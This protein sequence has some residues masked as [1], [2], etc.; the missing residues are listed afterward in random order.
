MVLFQSGRF[1]TWLAKEVASRISLA[2]GAKVDIRAVK[3]RFFDRAVLEG[4]YVEDLHKDTLLYVDFIEANFDEVYLGFKHFDF[5]HV[6]LRKGQFNVRQF[7]GEEDLN[8][9][10]ILDA[11]NGPRDTTKKVRSKPP[12]LFFW[13][14]DIEDV[15]FTYEYRDTIPD[16]GFGMNYDH[17]RIRDI[18]ANL[19][20]LIIIDDSLSGKINHM[21]LTE[22]SG[23]KVNDFSSDFV[24]AYTMMDFSNLHVQ[25]P[26]SSLDG[27]VHFEYDSYDDL[28]DFIEKV[29]MRGKIRKSSINLDEIAVFAPEL[30]GLNQQVKYSGGFKGSIDRLKGFNTMLSF[31]QESHFIGS[32]TM[33]G[34]PDTDKMAFDYQIVELQTSRA[35]L[36]DLEMYPFY[37][38]TKIAIPEMFDRAGVVSYRG[39]LSGTLDNLS[40]LGKLSSDLGEID[41]DLHL[42]FRSDVQQ[43]AYEGKFG[44]ANFMLGD[45]L[46]IKPQVGNLAF[47]SEIKG[48]GFSEE[49]LQTSIIGQLPFIQLNGYSYSNIALN[50]IV[51]GKTY[52]GKLSINDQNLKMDFSGLI[53]LT[54]PQP[55][56]DFQANIDLLNVTALKLLKRDSS[57]ILSSEIISNFKGKSLDQLE[58]QIELAQTS[59]Q[60]GSKKYHVEDVLLEANGEPDAKSIHLYSDMVDASIKG[61][62]RLATLPDAI[63]NVLNSFLPSYTAIKINPNQTFNQNFKY[64]ARIKDLKLISEVFFPSIQIGTGTHVLG[65]FQSEGNQ[66]R[67]EINSPM[68]NISGVRFE[69][70][71]STA[72]A[73]NNRLK[74]HIASNKMFI[75]DSVQVN[76]IS[77]SSDAIT[78]SLGL[79]INWASRKSLSAADAQI[80]ASAKFEGSKISMQMLPSLILI[81]DTLWQVNAEN[82]IE[83]DTGLV[84]F[85]NLSF[86]HQNEFIRIDGK[87]SSRETDELDVILDNFQLR[88][89]NP[90][91]SNSNL[92]LEGSTRG[93]ISV[94][95][96]LGQPFFK[97]DL[98]LKNIYIN[99]DLIGDGVISSKWDPK[100]ERILLD[101]LLK[102]S[103]VPKLAFNG[104]FIPSKEKNNIDL[105][106]DLNNIQLS[107]FKKYVDDLFSDVSGLADGNIHLTGSLE[108]PIT[109][110]TVNLK[111]T[112]LTIGLLNTR[113]FF[114]HEFKVSKNV[115]QAKNIQLTDENSNT[116]KLDI[117]ISHTNFDNFYFD[118][119]LKANS[120]LALNTN[121]TQSDLFYGKANATGTFRASGPLD[122][123]VMDIN[124]KTERGT[125]FYLPLTGTSDVSQQDFI[126]FEKKG[127]THNLNKVSTRKVSSKGYELNFNLEVTPEAEAF[128]LF[129]PKVGDII[130][131]NGSANL[132]MEVTEAGDFN[133][134]G[135]YIIDKGDYLF[136]L[137][138]VINKKF[139]V[140]KG[141]VI[142]FKGDPY[143]AD[144][145]LSAIY[146]VRT[147]L[148]NLVQ[149][150]DSS[151][152][153][154]RTIDVNAIMNLSDKLMKPQISF[155]ITLPN[156]D[157]N[158]I[159][160]FKS[161]I[162][163][164]DELNKQIFS[165][166]MFRSF[167]PNQ[168]GAT[169]TTGIN[170]VGSNA[171]ELL[172]SQ[173]SNMLSQLSD[174]VNIGVNYSQGGAAAKDNVSVN[175]QTQLFNDRVSI[176]GNVGTA[177]NATTSQNT[178][179][180]VGEFNVEVKL[181]DDG[182]VRIRVFN[183][184]NQY[185]LLSN[186]VPYT[187]GVGLFY[188]K[189][190][191]NAS[192][193]FKK[194]NKGAN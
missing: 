37:E 108:E 182:M 24:V 138:N 120:L 90:F 135:D 152:A 74:L 117:K 153:V 22:A 83:I 157:D 94:A 98:D 161:Q 109:N 170:G 44:T 193:L 167:M 71:N 140:Q 79:K 151:A 180:M 63:S 73:L 177:N 9:Q 114:A 156:A 7:E 60:Y 32:F 18:Y 84:E 54:K 191:E 179:N 132:R 133:I 100:T 178:T 23:F 58:G 160:L 11:I 3:I 82:S 118:V 65:D 95:D 162:Y 181:T 166:V 97:S 147:S 29:Q 41:T 25:T 35:D 47:T 42:W 6:T 4:F 149:N 101:G 115:I 186:D 175:L 155:D 171:S 8:I 53:D 146:K 26:K 33:D 111:R 189:E 194:K 14:V 116:G 20:N 124:A 72:D 192:D 64:D 144:I 49:Q 187:Q 176:D 91:I 38:K 78:D 105:Q 66:L 50:G 184:S 129:D 106:L 136:T 61:A 85:N 122:N 141:G 67:L 128:L 121:E 39:A 190:F 113:Y 185:L 93:I 70:I 119:F 154:K 89:L 107:L 34:L 76:H 104:Y 169:E 57:L 52:D 5:D 69:Q 36:L 43:Y 183:R 27:K 134:Y 46:G 172:S 165:L 88:N 92:K 2:I 131:G 127:T 87:V 142:S 28:S 112:A 173:L 126:T 163:S 174:D 21:K 13:D 59:V 56:F 81:E 143:D 15:D 159:N 130:K 19:K 55:E 125:V 139:V 137:Q 1:Q 77:L 51:N 12:E 86:T 148:Y 17:L 150:I 102:N 45:L 16:T 40:A 164:E 123:I 158:S 99:D 75:T 68:I 168:G 31:G 96:L 10:F 110:G 188:R 145:N 30:R 80:N 103:S 62:F 48:L